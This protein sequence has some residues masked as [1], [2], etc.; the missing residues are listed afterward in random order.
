MKKNK[1]PIIG[2]VLLGVLFIAFFWITNRQQ[3]QYAHQEKMK[4]D[5]IARVEA[6]KVKPLNVADSLRIDSVN[7]TQAAGGFASAGVGTESTIVV[8]N[9]LLRATF[10]SKGGQLKKVELKKYNSYNNAN[11]PVTIGGG[12][13]D[14]FG[15]KIN[16][17][18]TV[19]T[20]TNDLLFT[21]SQVVKN[22][23][24]SQ[25]LSFT[26]QSA[27][28]QK[29]EHAY[30]IRPNQYMINW[31][32]NLVGASSL[33]TNN[34]LNLHWNT[35]LHQQQR[36][37][38][39]EKQ[40]SRIV[41][42]SDNSFDYTT[43]KPTSDVDKKIEKPVNWIGFSQQF[44]NAT[45]AL[46]KE[47]F[48]NADA[49]MV[50]IADTASGQLFDAT[51][52][53]QLKLPNSATVSIPMQIYFGPNDYGI[54]KQYDN[55]MK[56]IVDLGSGMFSF[57]KYINRG[58][59]I[60]VFNFITGFVSNF[61]WAIAILT[62]VIR[63]ILAPLTYSSYKSGAKMKV[64]RPELDELKKK[65]GKDQ[66]GFAMEQMK[67]FREAGVNPMGGCIPILFQIPIFFS[68]YSFFG[69]NIALRGQSFLWAND[70]SSYDTFFHW[71]I[72]IPVLGYHLS[73]F[74]LL[75]SIT[76]LLMSLYNV[77]ATPQ[78]QDNPVLKYMPYMMPIIFLIWWNN[79]PSALTWYYTVSNVMTLLIQIFIQKVIISPEKVLASIEEKRKGPK[80]GKGKFQQ[81]LEQMAEMQ[82]KMQD[83]KD[84]ANKR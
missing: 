5:S 69:S 38:D 49:K 13:D 14:N 80:K 56:N 84:R 10:S 48:S 22:S 25:T 46:N 54:L 63:I 60:P 34:Q 15:Y 51:A 76:S 27:G 18:N 20:P 35:Q 24:G 65:Y 6:A 9:E 68:L 43:A 2:A 77:N 67:L 75:S 44:F 64:L 30:V 59:I 36:A 50:G 12:K 47:T 39:Y 52:D 58:V 74:T 79:M 72:H 66:Q 8:E 71:G 70:L 81:R 31:S 37:A 16:T 17:S 33:F 26:L 41:Y 7:K 78:T 53:M 3:E 29:I 61:G 28:G 42:Y 40:H 82:K 83:A 21:P 11:M 73:L 4:Q 62:L 1:M 23:D 45:L 19:S 55:G 32:I 57:V